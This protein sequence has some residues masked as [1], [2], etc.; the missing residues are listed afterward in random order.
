MQYER[1]G[2]ERSWDTLGEFKLLISQEPPVRLRITN[3]QRSRM[4]QLQNGRIHYNW[5]ATG[6]ENYPRYST[7]LSEFRGVF[8]KFADFLEKNSLGGIE[9]DQ[10]EITYVNHI[11]KETLWNSLEE[12]SKIFHSMCLD[13]RLGEEFRLDGFGTRISNEI[14]PQLGRLH[15]QLNH[16]KDKEG[17]E[18][19]R[20]DLTA[21]GP[22]NEQIDLWQ[23]I[24]LGH[25]SIVNAFYNMTTEEA[26][27]YWGYKNAR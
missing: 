26:H 11:Y 2:D 12:T 5:L 21:R 7:V 9:P 20:L 22:V 8:K 10:W 3:Q 15:V 19:L 17:K 24:D 6:G 13:P 23:G 25:K 14:K 4:V 27:K 16:A 1:F 18:T